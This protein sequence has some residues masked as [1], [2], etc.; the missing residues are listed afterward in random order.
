MGRCQATVR[1]CL[2][3]FGPREARIPG[4]RPWLVDKTNGERNWL[5]IRKLVAVGS[6]ICL[7][8][9]E[10]GPTDPAVSVRV[11][12]DRPRTLPLVETLD[13]LETTLLAH[14][15]GVM[16]QRIFDQLFPGLL[17]KGAKHAPLICCIVP[18]VLY[19]H[20]AKPEPTHGFLP[21]REMSQGEGC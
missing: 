11:K 14:D 21:K 9:Y 6:L 10:H 2:D 5:S 17:L 1:A 4:E 3:W 19:Y 12:S 18:H 8:R 13:S 15:A 20:A 16:R 7:G